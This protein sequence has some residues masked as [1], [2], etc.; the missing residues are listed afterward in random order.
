MSNFF[1]LF[2]ELEA[3]FAPTPEVVARRMMEIARLQRGEIFYDLGSGDGALLIMAAKEFGAR[4]IGVELQ[5]K[6]VECSRRRIRSLGLGSMVKVVQ[7]DLFRADISGADVLALYLM[8][9]ALSKLRPKLEREL[10]R[11]TR[12]AV[13]KYPMEGWKPAETHSITDENGETKI[14]LYEL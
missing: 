4:A 10:K 11:G 13:Y 5:R 7:G 1:N 12:V 6:F 3:G 2:V 14:F 8:P 9:K